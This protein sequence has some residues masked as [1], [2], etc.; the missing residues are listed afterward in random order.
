VGRDL[1]GHGRGPLG[2]IS[3]RTWY[4][5]GKE[6]YR[7]VPSVVQGKYESEAVLKYFKGNSGKDLVR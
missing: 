5:L 6:L 1:V 4:A 3:V 2:R 7:R